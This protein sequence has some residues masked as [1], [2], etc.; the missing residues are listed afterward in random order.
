MRPRSAE[1]RHHQYRVGGSV[2]SRFIGR[3]VADI[4]VIDDIARL[5]ISKFVRL[6]QFKADQAFIGRS[7]DRPVDQAA[8][9]LLLQD[10]DSRQ[11]R[12]FGVLTARRQSLEHR[13]SPRI[14]AQQPVA[15]GQH[16]RVKTSVARHKF[17]EMDLS[18]VGDD[19]IV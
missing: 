10:L 14:V 7:S 12:V 2:H 4:V 11:M 13:C 16:R 5:Q 17:I 8:P 18:D 15:V 3:I 19:K 9:D 6:G 1:H